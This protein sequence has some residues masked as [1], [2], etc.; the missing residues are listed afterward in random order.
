[1]D[2]AGSY[3]FHVPQGMVWAALQDPLVLG[4]VVHTC[5]GVE[6]VGENE[7]VGTLQFKAGSV[8][9]V[10]KGTIKLLNIQALE[11]YDVEV[12]GK[13]FPAW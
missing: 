11:S 8:Q 12:N 10:F 2:I 13:G 5:W 7:Y 4:A 3:T 1:M 9:G 6:K